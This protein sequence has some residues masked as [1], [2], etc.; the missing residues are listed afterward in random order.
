MN[1]HVNGG[2]ESSHRYLKEAI[3]QALANHQPPPRFEAI[4]LRQVFT[5]DPN[6]VLLELNFFRD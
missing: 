3:E 2:V 6:G 5:Q 1:V 4:G